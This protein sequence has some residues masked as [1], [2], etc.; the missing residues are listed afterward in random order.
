[1]IQDGKC[2]FCEEPIKSIKQSDGFMFNCPVCGKYILSEDAN[3]QVKKYSLQQLTHCGSHCITTYKNEGFQT[4]WL[5][6]DEYDYAIEH[7]TKCINGFKWVNF[8]E[9]CKQP[10]DHSAKIDWLLLAWATRLIHTSPYGEFNP[11]KID[12]IYCNIGTK[13]ELWQLLQFAHGERFITVNHDM[14]G[15]SMI[16]EKVYR[17]NIRLTTL[18]WKHIAALNTATGSREVFIAMK[19]KWNEKEPAEIAIK[20]AC[21]RCGY[22][23]YLVSDHDHNDQITDRI[24]AGIKKSR[25]VVADF[26]F[27]NRGVYYEAGYARGLGIP[28]I[29]TIKKGHIKDDTDEQKRLHFDI[30]QINYLEW[31]TPSDLLSKL[32]DK[33]QATIDTPFSS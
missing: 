17:V 19:F 8:D 12:R 20:Q 25:F 18:G 9:L 30:Q 5:T 31:E 21:E 24:I 2:V 15:A 32:I 22:K 27:N 7:K 4:F 13:D 6:K 23:A 11:T 29:H 10:V 14:S 26:T 33:I 3:L 16:I 1:M 28:V